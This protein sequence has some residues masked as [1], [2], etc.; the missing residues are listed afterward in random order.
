MSAKLFPNNELSMRYLIFHFLEPKLIAPVVVYLCHENSTDNGSIIE[1][2]AGWAAKVSVSFVFSDFINI[3][4]LSFVFC[5]LTILIN[6]LLSFSASHGAR[7]RCS[8]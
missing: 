1:S 8:P 5:L 4:Y 7:Q 6:V 3:F 2:A